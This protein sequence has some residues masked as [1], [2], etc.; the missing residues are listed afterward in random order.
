MTAE[1]TALGGDA[2]ASLEA[3][4]Y[5]QELKR[6]LSFWE[7]LTFGLIMIAPTAPFAVFGFVYNR[8][9]GMV[10]LVYAI[11]LAAMLF[12]A[13]SYRTMAR[14]FP[15]AGS[16]YAYAGR[17]IGPSAG[18]IAGWAIL[19]DYL[20]VPTLVYVF[21][22]TAI[23]AVAPGIP[24]WAL[25]VGF[26]AAVTAVNLIGVE[27]ASWFNKAM[28]WAQL[29]LLVVFAVLASRAL[30]HGTGG[31]HLSIAPFFQPKFIT[32]SLIFG[33]LSVAALSFLGF[34]AVSTLSEEARGGAKAVGLATVLTLIISAGLFIAQT[35]LACL[36][37]LDTPSF[38]NGD[39]SDNAMLNILGAL[40][41]PVFKVVSSVIGIALGS[42]ACALVA[43]AACARLIYGMAR[44][45][46]LPPFLAHVNERRK[47][48]DRA[49]LLIAAITLGTGLLLVD[50]LETLTSLV[51]FGAL[52]GF[53]ML[54]LS[55][56]IHFGLKPGRNVWAHVV[57]PVIGFAVIGYVLWNTDTTAK[58]AGL[59]WLAIGIGALIAMKLLGRPVA[60]PEV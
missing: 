43:Q 46:K 32:P 20:L 60:A 59:I 57:T 28:M 33:A 18:F 27:A 11:G 24:K 10:A 41:G 4:G 40:G 22:A 14:A 5:R 50:K 39:A 38:A 9:H 45:R 51:N 30:A 31:A 25:V 54:H 13:L 49:T 19:L 16:V 42:V 52:T 53:L 37:L 7:L 8:S 3:M 29:A 44:D 1:G 26:L 23:H 12:T 6:T 35:W 58:I 2:T 48:P 34:D 21:A 56:L 15:V 17:G 55:V 36:F 47:T